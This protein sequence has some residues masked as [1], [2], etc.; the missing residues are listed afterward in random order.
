MRKVVFQ[1]KL[2]SFELDYLNSA[3]TASASTRLGRVERGLCVCVCVRERETKKIEVENQT[4]E[5]K[6]KKVKRGI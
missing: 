6:G 3:S 2:G 4:V 5:R 1:S